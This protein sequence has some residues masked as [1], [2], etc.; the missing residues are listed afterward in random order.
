MKDEQRKKTASFTCPS[1]AFTC[2]PYPDDGVKPKD[3]RH[4]RPKDISN[5][6]ALG[7][8]ITA[9]FAMTSGM[10]PFTTLREFRGGVFDIGGDKGERTIANYLRVYNPSLRGPSNGLTALK[11]KSMLQNSE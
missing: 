11:T 9:G 4:V 3:V 2:T 1:K 10:F 5:I 6:M 7:D 8:S